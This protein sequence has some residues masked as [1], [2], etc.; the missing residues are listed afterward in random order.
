MSLLQ[1]I[2]LAFGGPTALLAAA[3]YLS[4]TLITQWTT[5]EIKRLDNK[6]ALD[7]EKYKS[8]VQLANQIKTED[9]KTA[10]QIR[11]FEHQLKFSKIYEKRAEIIDSLYKSL[12]K[13]MQDLQSAQ[14][15]MQLAGDIPV[16]DKLEIAGRSYNELLL[17]FSA[18][19]IYIPESI[20]I[21]IDKLISRVRTKLIHQGGWQRIPMDRLSP[22]SQMKRLDDHVASWKEIS[23]EF[24]QIL[25]KLESEFRKILEPIDYENPFPSSQN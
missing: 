5:K 23:E 14:A 17:Y 6:L 2:I 25:R 13:A 1:T 20:A 10:L 4:K 19:R 24:P 7:I 21:D 16:S 8:E 12:V 9:K 15:P 18:N 3:A 11:G 22:E